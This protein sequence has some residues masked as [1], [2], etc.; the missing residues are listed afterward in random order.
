L[1]AYLGLETTRGWS[2]S[3][4]LRAAPALF[5][6][7]SVVALLDARLPPKATCADFL[8]W[9]GKSQRTFSGAITVL[10]RWLWVHWVFATPRHHHACAK[11]SGP[12]R[13]VLL[14]APAA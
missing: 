4:V 10:R 9:P 14:Y 3:T 2:E 5:G 12:T 13:A 1:R 11:R 6:L 8:A 7:F